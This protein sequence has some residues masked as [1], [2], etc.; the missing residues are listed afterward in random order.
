MQAHKIN[1]S[2]KIKDNRI[3]PVKKFLLIL[4]IF[5]F[6]AGVIIYEYG[7]TIYIKLNELKLLPEEEH[8]TELYFENPSALFFRAPEGEN[9]NYSFTI[10]NLEGADKEYYYIVY[11]MPD[12]RRVKILDRNTLFVKNNEKR[13]IN[14]TYAF[15]DKNDKGGGNIYIELPQLDQKIHFNLINRQ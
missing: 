4:L 3:K 7:S 15:L 1:N 10:H 13:T 8:F 5:C 12:A 11:Y 9:I 6:V 14:E 2:M